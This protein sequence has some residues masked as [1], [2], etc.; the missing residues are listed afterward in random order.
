MT[1]YHIDCR[2]CRNKD[3]MPNGDVYCRP[4]RAGRPAVYIEDGHAGT[5]EDPD[6]VMCDE[7][8]PPEAEKGEL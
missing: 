8:Q 5:R 3:I 1:V 2:R 4:M 7:Y 6:P